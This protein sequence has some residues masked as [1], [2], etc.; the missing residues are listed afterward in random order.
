MQTEHKLS[1]QMEHSTEVPLQLMI[2]QVSPDTIP[3]LVIWKDSNAMTSYVETEMA[4]G[5]FCISGKF[6]QIEHKL[7]WQMEHSSKVPP[8]LMIS[9]VSPN[10]ILGLVIWKDS[11]AIKKLCSIR[12]Y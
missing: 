12:L 5:K 4:N 8:Q 11:N 7:S 6:R 2:S 9:R 10:T 1:W 3:G